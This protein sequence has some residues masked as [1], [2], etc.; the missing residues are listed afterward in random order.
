V[1]RRVP[2]VCDGKNA[3]T[4]AL[5]GCSN[6]LHLTMYLCA[7]LFDISRSSPAKQVRRGQGKEIF[8]GGSCNPTTWRKDI[9]IPTLEAM[10][11]PYYNP[12]VRHDVHP[13][14]GAERATSRCRHRWLDHTS[15]GARF[16]PILGDSVQLYRSTTGT[17][18]LSKLRPGQKLKL[19]C[20]SL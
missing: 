4:L 17:Q 1:F 18:S 20:N 14:P 2:S 12:Q 15:L 9:V 19:L 6:R 13:P 16:K 5:R 11:V 8:L 10:G 3:H 7:H